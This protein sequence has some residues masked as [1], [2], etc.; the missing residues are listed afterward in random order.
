MEDQE[1]H[2]ES[3]DDKET[4]SAFDGDLAFSFDF[5]S[6]DFA[7]VEAEI[8]NVEDPLSDQRAAVAEAVHALAEAVLV[9]RNRIGFFK[10]VI[11]RVIGGDRAVDVPRICS[12]LD[13]VES[14]YDVIWKGLMYEENIAT[15]GGN[16]S[17]ICKYIQTICGFIDDDAFAT[18][19][20][21]Q[22]N[23]ELEAMLSNLLTQYEQRVT[24]ELKGMSLDPITSDSFTSFWDS[25]ERK[26]G[27]FAVIAKEL[28]KISTQLG[29]VSSALEPFTKT[30]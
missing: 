26:L 7:A 5:D 21:I 20:F 22:R 9:K 28:R 8:A 13:E 14:S 18:N 11:E 17:L 10:K 1:E 25:H 2:A 29:E 3:A 19:E 4:D 12:L 30:L 15:G 24:K 23:Q 27:E 16:I 6:E